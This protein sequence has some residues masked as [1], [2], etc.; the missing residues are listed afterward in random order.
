M[1]INLI[2]DLPDDIN[3]K[4]LQDDDIYSLTIDDTNEEKNTNEIRTLGDCGLGEFIKLG[5][6]E[7]VVLGHDNDT[8]AIITNSSVTVMSYGSNSNY[9]DSQVREFCNG[10]FYEELADTVGKE[11][12][13]PH[14]VN[15]MCDDGTN[16]RMYCEDNVSILTDDKYRRYREY[17]TAEDK[18]SWLATGVSTICENETDNV[19]IVGISGTISNIPFWYNSGVRPICILNSSVIIS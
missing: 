10:E 19:C 14:K 15:L 11:N 13:I 8:T 7:Y 4:V 9:I 1:K 18:S 6:R 17:I 3:I 5:D 2:N 12:I 16:K